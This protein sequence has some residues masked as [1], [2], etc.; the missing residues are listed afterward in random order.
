MK[1]EYPVALTPKQRKRLEKLTRGGEIKV[2]KYKRARILLL[3]DENHPK[4][5]KTDAAIA[6]QV[7]VAPATVLR[8][9]KRFVQEGLAA[10]LEEKPRSGAPS[11]FSGQE[12]A[13]V[14]ALACS[15]PPE[16]HARW[17][18]RL[19]ADR[20]VELEL[21]ESISHDTVDRILKKTNCSLTASDSGASES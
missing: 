17:S 4:G 19:L 7:G 12:M 6:E 13:A 10:A 3:A 18:L 8:I 2:R 14:T 1:K 16:G 5:G 9:R 21:V 15:D 11:K 20:L